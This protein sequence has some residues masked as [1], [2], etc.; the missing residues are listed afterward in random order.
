MRK[1][2]KQEASLTKKVNWKERKERQA[3]AWKGINMNI[4]FFGLMGSMLYICYL[5]VS[6]KH[7]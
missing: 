6:D 1:A 3:V 5:G 2:S 4:I 7:E